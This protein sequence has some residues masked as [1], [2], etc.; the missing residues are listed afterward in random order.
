M[1]RAAIVGCG[2]IAGFLDAPTDKQVVTHAHAFAEASGIELAACCDPDE[3]Q[4]LAFA[5]R[6]GIPAAYADVQTL[7]TNEQ[8]DILSVCSP[9]PFHFEALSAALNDPRISTLICEK[10]VVQS[11]EELDALLPLLEGTQKKVTINF[12]RRFDPSIREAARVIQSGELGELRH[13]S[14]VFT[15]GL[16]HNGS[17]MLELVEHLCGGI[18]AITALSCTREEGDLFGSFYLETDK[19]RGT[20]N[21]ESGEAYALFELEIVL[22]RGRVRIA[23][24]GHAVQIETPSASTRYA[25][26]S[27]LKKNRALDDTLLYY[28]RNSLEAALEG[29][30]SALRQHLELSRKLLDIKERL[31]DMK[32][33]NWRSS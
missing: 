29:D 25:G 17:H 32:T 18:V 24:L 27:Y 31:A 14:G 19:A 10:P 30:R 3:A 8:I 1:M 22:S 2:N 7:L 26:Y 5:E 4:R 9:T 20:L 13:F 6:W 23:D 16:Y 33:I 11:R 12:I 15:K 28:A 21:N